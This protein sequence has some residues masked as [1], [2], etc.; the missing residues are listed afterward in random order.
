MCVSYCWASVRV[1]RPFDSPYFCQDRRLKIRFTFGCDAV[2]DLYKFRIDIWPLVKIHKSFS[3][4]KI[5]YLFASCL[6]R[7]FDHV[8]I[9]ISNKCVNLCVFFCFLFREF[10]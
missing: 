10:Y 2:F 4:G 7:P 8:S 6:C 9:R 1:D 3:A 5:V